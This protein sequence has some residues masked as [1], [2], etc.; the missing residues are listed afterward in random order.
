MARAYGSNTQLLLKYESS[1]G[2]DPAGNYQR[3]P[4]VSCDLGAEQ[5]LL[6][7]DIIG[8]G[9]DPSAPFRDLV[10]VGGQ[11]T[12]PLDVRNIG[13]WLKLVFGAPSTSGTGP[14]THTFV[15]GGASLPSAAIEIGHSEVPAFFLILGCKADSV[16]FELSRTGGAQAVITL[17]GQDEQKNATTQGGTPVA[18]LTLAR[19]NQ[20]DGN[21]QRNDT[22]LASI[23]TASMEFRNNLEAVET[24]RADALVEGQDET[25]T[26]LSGSISTRFASTTLYDD[27]VNG[28]ALDIDIDYEIDASNKLSLNGQEIYLPRTKR[29]VSGPGG[30]EASFDFQGSKDTTEGE[31]FEAVLINDVADYD[32][33]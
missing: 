21:I 14:Y 25:M 17:A 32:I 8:T 33:T 18:A 1:Y 22:D 30:V 27:A 20:V 3:L 24:I 9:R 28:T 16:R 12:V 23:L 4:F 29:N 7:S 10:R 19:F 13:F 31:L 2:V 15:S 5:G 11:I 26:A 6:D